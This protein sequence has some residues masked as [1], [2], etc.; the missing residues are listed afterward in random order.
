MDLGVKRSEFKSQTYQCLVLPDKI[1]TEPHIV[2]YK[3]GRTIITSTMR[4]L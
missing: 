4:L 1:L 2:I 3:S